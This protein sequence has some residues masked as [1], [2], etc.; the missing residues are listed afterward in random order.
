LRRGSPA[1]LPVGVEGWD[2]NRLPHLPLPFHPSPAS[3]P[4]VPHP[5]RFCEGWDVNR[6]HHPLFSPLVSPS[7]VGSDNLLPPELARTP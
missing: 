6:S 5:S 4:R 3:K 7:W 1:S 2:V